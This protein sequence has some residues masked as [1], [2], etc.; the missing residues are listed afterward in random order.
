MSNSNGKNGLLLDRMRKFVAVLT[1]DQ[2]T[3]HH[4]LNRYLAGQDHSAFALLVKRH[5]PMVLGVCWRVLRHRQD[6]ED[7]FQATFLVLARKAKTIRQ[8]ESLAGWLYRVALR[9]SGKLRLACV[10]RLNRQRPL[11]D[12]P[13]AASGED[14]SYWETQRILE[15][16]L[17]RLADKYRAPLLL[18]CIQGRTRDEAAHQL[19]WSVGVLRG[20]LDRGREILRTRLARRGIALTA[21]LWG[22]GNAGISEAALPLSLCSST[23]RAVAGAAHTP[24]VAGAVSAQAAALAQGVIQAMFITKL[25]SVFVG[26]FTLIFLGTGAGFITC[27]VQADDG[28]ERFAQNAPEPKQPAR[29]DSEA[30][31]RREIERLKLEL[32]QTRHLLKLANQEILDLRASRAP[33]AAEEKQ[34]EDAVGILGKSKVRKGLG[35]VPDETSPG[36][37]SDRK[38]AIYRGVTSPDGKL[39][40]VV[41]EKSLILLDTATGKEL[42]RFQGHTDA[43]KS[44]AFSPDGK[45][46]ASAGKDT[47]VFLW[48]IQSGKQVAKFVAQFPVESIIFSPDGK[49]LRIRSGDLLAE[50]DPVTGTLTTR[51]EPLR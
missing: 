50:F 44:L 37:T 8:S 19:G 47:A 28:P 6:A 23:I 27:H 38:Q 35:V 14:I 18:C 46:L 48:E 2:V 32:E 40:A 33:A 16:E 13:Q 49:T 12:I 30:E 22:V 7:A 45:L 34:K 24:A 36:Q 42:R 31:L 26:L 11:L 51:K 17:N 15:E 5:G 25:K 43:I 39:D 3:D 21:A 4:L 9:A 20:R 41:H 1:A 10:R 29:K